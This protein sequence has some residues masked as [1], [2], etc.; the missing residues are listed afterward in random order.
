MKQVKFLTIILVLVILIGGVACSNQAADEDCSS[1]ELTT[2]AAKVVVDR[3]NSPID[4]AKATKSIGDDR[5][6][7][8]DEALKKNR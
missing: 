7:E 6:K 3:I 1:N 5:V 4:K 2:K 8:M